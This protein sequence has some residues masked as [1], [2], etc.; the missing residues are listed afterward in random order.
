MRITEE[1]RRAWERD[2]AQSPF[3]MWL[4]AEVAGPDGSF[5]LARLHSVARQYGI[6][7]EQAYAH[8]NPGQQRMSIGNM[9]RSRVPRS[10][11]ETP[12][13]TAEAR[14]FRAAGTE[15]H[16]IIREAGVRELLSLHAQILDELRD[17]QIVRTSNSPLGDY[18][19][20]LFA[21]AFGWQLNDNSSAGHDAVDAQGVRYQ[22][23]AR[24]VTPKNPSR[25]LSAIRRLPDR[26]FDVLA[27]VLFDA[28]Y[29]VFK[30]LLLPYEVVQARARHVEHTNSWRFMADDK[31]WLVAGAQDVTTDI[32]RVAETI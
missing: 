22:I 29:Q 8:L 24:R 14:D 4:N 1:Q 26:T 17:R 2:T 10:L 13:V 27:C 5:D 20:L 9:L 12:A 30:A 19:E 16:E 21:S 7:R 15:R 11:Y 25:Q 6:D 32:A 23:K 31:L 28:G 18:A 3:N